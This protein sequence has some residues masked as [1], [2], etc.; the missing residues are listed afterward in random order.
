MIK[1]ILLSQFDTCYNENGWFVAVGNVIDGIGVEEAAWK[2]IDEVNCI[3][4]SLSHLTYYNDANLQRFKGIDFQHS[5]SHNNDTF[6]TG[7]YEEAEWQADVARFDRIMREFRELIATADEAKFSQSVSAQNPATWAEVIADI[8]AH[9][10]Y[11]A[12]QMLLML[13]LQGKWNPSKGVS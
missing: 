7:E 5:I 12:G 8:N 13:K 10:A 6:N 11:H 3:W 9:N 4:E 2:E 1:E